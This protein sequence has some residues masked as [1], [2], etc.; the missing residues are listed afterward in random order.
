MK[1]KNKK[2]LTFF[3]S[4]VKTRKTEFTLFGFNEQYLLNVYMILFFKISVCAYEYVF[5]LG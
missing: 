1:R 5:K 3:I 4:Y 2:D